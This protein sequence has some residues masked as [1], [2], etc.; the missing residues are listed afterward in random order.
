MKQINHKGAAMPDNIVK[1]EI[2]LSDESVHKIV[3]AE[4]AKALNQVEGFMES[5][6]HEVLFTRPA[7]QN[8]Y[9]KTPKTFYE[10]AVISVLTPMVKEEI[11]KC[12]EKHR[13]KLSAIISKC[14]KSKIIDNRE[15]E[16]RLIE[17]L[18][19]FSSNIN[20]YVNNEE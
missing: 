16:D 1:T 4:T 7:K 19:K 3:V 17:R 2:V 6:V 15:F 20:F 18:S 12:A 10:R 11:E 14:F 8:S 9:D 13:K 5:L